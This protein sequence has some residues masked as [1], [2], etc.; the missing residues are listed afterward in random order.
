MNLIVIDTET[1]GLNPETDSILSLAVVIWRDRELVDET[2]IFVCEPEMRMDAESTRI[3]GIEPDWLRRN[4]SLPHQAV[5]KLEGFIATRLPDS[6]EGTKFIL[7]GHNVGFDVGF[8]KRL[9]RLA[10]RDFARHFSHRTFDTAST[11]LFL[12]LAGL[13]PPGAASSDEL[14]GYFKIPFGKKERH[15]ALGDA[16][17]TARLINSM[18]GLMDNARVGL[19]PV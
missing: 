6:P 7:A 16:R 19:A 5:S 2:Q 12:I 17:A 13:L 1:G 8:L 4:G 11:G 3:H 15:S 10:G 14:F 9:Y 18:L